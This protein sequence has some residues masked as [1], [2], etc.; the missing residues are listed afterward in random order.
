MNYLIILV[1]A[2]AIWRIYVNYK[3]NIKMGPEISLAVGSIVTIIGNKFF[4]DSLIAVILQLVLMY[5]ITRQLLRSRR[6]AE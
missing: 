4:K 3:S 2:Y 1:F 6:E 5:L